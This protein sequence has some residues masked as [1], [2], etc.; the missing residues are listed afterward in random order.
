MAQAGAGTTGLAPPARVAARHV[1]PRIGL[2]AVTVQ[3]WRA[4]WLMLAIFL[5]LF[6]I[7]LAGAFA[8]PRSYVSTSR[9][10]VSLGDRYVYRPAA[11]LEMGA[12]APAEIEALVQ[13]EVELLRSPVVAQAA[14]AKVTLARAYPEIARDCRPE[15]C[16]R[17]GVAA[18][19]EYLSVSDTPRNRVIVARFVHRQPA[20]SAELLNALI[21]AYFAYRAGLFTDDRADSFQ[22]RREGLAQDLAEADA[23]IRDYLLTN[24]LTDLAAERETLRQLYQAASSELLV[25][26]SRL[27]Q[28]EAQLANY[29]RQIDSIDP[30]QDLYVED[31]SQQTLLALRLERE[32]KLS[33]YR[34]DSRVIRDLDMRIE[35]TESYMD[36]RAAPAGIVRRGPNPLYQQIEAAIATLQS[37][38]QALRGQETELKA[39]I[40]AFEARQRRLLELEPALQE[41]QR[42]RD[43]AE[44][45]VRA[46]SEREVEAR[47]RDDFALS[48]SDIVRVL[49]PATPPITGANLKAPA[50][51]FVLVFAGLAALAA[52]VMRA[53]T[54]RGFATPGS[55]ERTL[56]LPVLAAVPTYRA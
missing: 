18:I 26:Q 9:L 21:D 33:R 54:R 12:A 22:K 3:L 42:N 36:S 8:M 25:A 38:V 56:G 39:Q 29:R 34:A 46:L 37:E 15:A 41:L 2:L 5:P 45:S 19:A 32:E 16:E 35:Q 28:S 24:N 7:G 49:E 14:L 4:K 27:R 31:S 10:L 53:L 47:V 13:S 1:R 40:A 50:A 51:V 44:R 17:L 20:M 23:A 6:L 52:G 55:A 43:V 30:A 11:G 48:L